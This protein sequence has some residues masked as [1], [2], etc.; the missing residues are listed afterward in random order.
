M[1][2]LTLITAFILSFT[3]S[4]Q[5]TGSPVFEKSENST[6]KA[7]W[8]YENG[9]VKEIGYFKNGQKHGQWF[10]YDEKGNL[11]S[12]ANYKE[13]QKDGN[14]IFYHING[15]LHYQVAYSSGKR[16]LYT[17][18]DTNGQLVAGVQNK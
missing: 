7:T 14:W 2:S 4:A 6:I 12:E 18:W 8:H 15:T 1:R 3:V 9:S 11:I 17:E 10:S 13:G 5:S 16:I